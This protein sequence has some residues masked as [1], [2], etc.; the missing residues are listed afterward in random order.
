VDDTTRYL[1]NQPV[2]LDHPPSQYKLFNS[3]KTDAQ[4]WERLL[5]SSGGLLKIKKCKYYL[6]QWQFCASGQARMV[7]AAEANLPPFRLTEGNSD[8]HVI[9][10]QLDC[11][12]SFRTL[13]IHKTILGDQTDQIKILK[14][15]S[16]NFGKGL[17]ASL[18][19]AF[20]AWTGYFTIWYPSI[21]YPLAATFL[22][23]AVCEKIQS[24]AICTTLT[25]CGFNRHLPRAIVFSSP[26]YGG[27]G[28][29]HVSYE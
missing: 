22:P 28:W 27:M 11:Q 23:R 19:N 2:W 26:L 15:K 1:C 24:F 8:N 10:D 25:K 29:R 3:L 12:D 13:G 21:N 5:W 14:E 20:E 17:L 6:V 7:T 16:D 18:V 9:V 4:I